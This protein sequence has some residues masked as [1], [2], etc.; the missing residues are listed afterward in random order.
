M[1]VRDPSLLVTE[2]FYGKL[3]RIDQLLRAGADIDAQ[4]GTSWNPLHAAVE[5][6]DLDAV[7]LLL[8]RGANVNAVIGGWTP[9]FHA[10]NLESSVASN[11]SPFVPPTPELSAL[12][13]R[14]GADPR[15]PAP[16]GRSLL[17]YFSYAA[18]KTAS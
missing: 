5:N 11:R 18:S 12:L 1:H 9:L 17:T 4:D 2:A 13:I 15:L 7:R 6:W 8:D 14:R 16:D 3:D 10:L